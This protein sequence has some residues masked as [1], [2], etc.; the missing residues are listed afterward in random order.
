VSR[1]GI[2][3][4]LAQVAIKTAAPGVPDFYQGTELWDFSLVDPDNRRP[5]DYT[6]R[7]TLLCDLDTSLERDGRTAV[8]ERLLASP[9]DDRMKLYATS[10]LLRLRSRYRDVFAQGTYEP[11][12][13]AGPRG[14]HV[15]AFART[16]GERQVLVVVPRLVSTLTPDADVPPVGERVWGD[17]RIVL[18]PWAS[19]SY[20][21]ALTDR[22]VAAREDGE[23]LT[24]RLAEVLDVFPIACLEC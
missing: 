23:P 12:T 22:C 7:R 13:A 15:F 19:R 18:P 14:E 3:N 8:A 4:S 5:V 20:R 21:D 6:R 10:T 1:Y 17:T 24:L 16:L 11:L 2:Y 9:G